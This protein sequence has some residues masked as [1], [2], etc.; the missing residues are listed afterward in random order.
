MGLPGLS[1]CRFSLTVVYDVH[2]GNV[3]SKYSNF[4]TMATQM[5]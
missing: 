2:L 4:C 3:W 1:F 5:N